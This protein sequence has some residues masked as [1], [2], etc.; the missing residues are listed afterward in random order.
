MNDRHRKVRLLITAATSPFSRNKKTVRR[1]STRR[2]LFAALACGIA[3]AILSGPASAAGAPPRPDGP[4][5]A[6]PQEAVAACVGKSVGASVS[7]TGPNGEQLSGE[8]RQ[9]GDTLAAMPPGG[10]PPGGRQP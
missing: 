6:P 1:L 5:P 4:P 3:S 8:C 10:P 9:M 2:A 7:F